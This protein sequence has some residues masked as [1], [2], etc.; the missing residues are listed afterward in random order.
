MNISLSWLKDYINV[1]EGTER[2]SEILTDIGLEVGGVEEVETVKGGLKSLVIGEVKDCIQHPNADKLKCTKVDVGQKEFLSIV[3]GAPNVA[4]GQKVVV[5]TIGTVLYSGDDSF[6]IKKSKL[7]GELSEGMICAKDEIGLGEGHDGI[8]VLENDAEIGTPAAEYFNVQSNQIIEVDLTPN[9]ADAMCHYGVAR[10]LAAYYAYHN[11]PKELVLPEVNISLGTSSLVSVE[12]EDKAACPYYS[13]LVIEHINVAESPDWLKEKLV[14]IGLNPVN[15]V[16]DITN[17]V[18]HETGQPLHAFDLREVGTKVIVKKGVN[19]KFTLLDGE[20]IELNKED[21]MICNASGPMCIA[22]VFGGVKSGVKESTTS[23]FLESAYFNAVD[24][25]KGSKRHALKTD[26]SYRFERGVAPQ[27]VDYA[28]ERC[29]SLLVELAGAKIVSNKI[30]AGELPSLFHEV[31]FN[32]QKVKASL[33]LELSEEQILSALEVLEIEV[34]KSS[35]ESWNLNVP[36]YRVDVTREVDV[37]EDILR[38]HGYNAVPMK[39]QFQFS[40]PTISGKPKEVIQS[41]VS[42]FLTGKGFN[43]VLNNSLSNAG[44]SEKVA[45][46]DDSKYVELLNPLSNELAVLRQSLV[47][48]VLESLVRNQNKKQPNNRFFEFGKTYMKVDQQKYVESNRLVLAISGNNH[49]EHW[50]EKE[51][52]VSF[53]HLIGDL[54]SLF[55]KTIQQKV[56]LKSSENDLYDYHV[57]LK[58]GKKLLGSIGKVNTR[59]AKKFGMKSEVF[60]ADIDWDMLVDLTAKQNS[61]YKPLRKFHPVVRDLSLLI[62]QSVQYQAIENAVFQVERELLTDVELFDVYQGDKLPEGKKSYAM[63]FE[64]YSDEQTLKDKEINK[65]MTKIQSSLEKEFGAELR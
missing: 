50:S 21:L 27:M 15:N 63:R 9:R 17:F 14:S 59:L 7:R 49:Q 57:D 36:S 5:A 61:R 44:Y 40:L 65:I 47:F 3:C 16:V 55:D 31:E 39:E 23:I 4:A 25:R 43:E 48:G 12:I 8:L 42:D 30:V 52:P 56:K 22:G 51:T 38:I 41:K 58:V 11:S 26:A 34:D 2:L 45:S 29:A 54:R 46:I 37:L 20:T 24:V 19:D 62:D 35:K 18:L 10:D 6:K 33:G 28:L 32:P 64:L 60:F 53:Y 13:G 1:D